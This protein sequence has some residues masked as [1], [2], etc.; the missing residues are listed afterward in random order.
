[1]KSVDVNSSTCI[2]FGIE[3]N[4][5]VPKFKVGVHVIIWKYTSIFAEGYVTNWSDEL[6]AIKK[7]KNTAPCSYLIKDLIREKNVA[8]F[9]EKELQKTNQQKSRVEKGTFRKSGTLFV[10]WK[11]YDDF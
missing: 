2:N 1:M 6:F 8:T 7:V 10:K 4:D 5:E 9:Y 3:K 11:V